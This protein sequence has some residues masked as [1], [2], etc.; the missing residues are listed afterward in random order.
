MKRFYWSLII[1]FVLNISCKTTRQET[2]QVFFV[3]TKGDD[4]A[5]G[6]KEVPFA[7]LKKALQQVVKL[8]NPTQPIDIFIR[9]GTYNIQN[10]I[11]IN[12]HVNNV[13][14]HAYKNEKVIFSG[15]ISLPVATIK[16][17][18]QN[19]YQINLKKAGITNYGNIRN[20]GF[21]RP[22]SPSWGELFV[23]GKAF[24]LARWPNKRFIPIGKV[25]DAGSIPR[26]GDFFKRGA[27]FKYDSLRISQWKKSKDIWI[28]GYFCYGYADDAVKVSKIDTLHKTITT[29]QP[30]LYGFA[31]GA[32]F[33]RW[34]AFNIFEELDEDK[35]FFIDREKGILYFVSDEKE[36]KTLHFSMLETPFFNIENAKNI[37]I[38]GIDFKYSRGIGIA[39]SNTKNVIIKNCTFSNLGS[40]GVTIGK[41]II[42]FKDYR[43]D[44]IGIPKS[45]IIGSLQQHLYANTTL[46]REGG[47][48]NSI[49]D[50]KFY[51]LGGGG[52]SLGGGNRKTLTSG[53]N[54]VENCVFHDVNRIEKS[55]RPAVHLTGV[56]NKII[57]CEIYNTPSMAVLMHGN[58]HLI[59]YN[60]IHD[61]V[62]NADDQGAF[63]YGRDPSERGTI[64][65][66]NYFENIPDKYST[67]AIYNDDGACGL[68]VEGNVFY[69]S[70]MRN[71]LLGGGSDNTYTNNIFMNAKIGI[72][73][74]N[75][76][77]NWSARIL[78]T[79]GLIEKRLKD[80]NYHQS[81]YSTQ[82]PA[83]VSYLDN[84]ALPKGN[85]VENNVFYD[86]EK[87]I[88]GNKDWL[89]F[90]NNLITKKDL[91]FVDA[92]NRNFELKKTSIV[93]KELPNFKKIPFNKI[94]LYK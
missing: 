32:D 5:K 37:I 68:I 28:S 85:L 74:D 43:H 63:Y 70:G 87:I 52:V 93:Y 78:A 91:D 60:Y 47:E 9:E 81:P 53:N 57:H 44:G 79:G 62:L 8:K 31:N 33:Q 15:G 16:K 3:S 17:N 14:I 30:T 40:L 67:C 27:V 61:V 66:Y 35:E 11:Q 65:R 42:P 20:V 77:Q 41:G 59:V 64:I 10:T 4:S 21:A 19:S 71:V 75:R 45:G 50:C 6:T 2:K 39:M 48:D 86:V 58:N 56:G 26:N 36:L 54:R 84:A 88:D 25:L 34:Y 94:G 51:Q 7:T 69:K 24:H 46:N 29:A 83:L 72:H 92:K 22:L 90:K 49:I 82:Y 55:Y 73:V 76:L 18:D 89:I 13:R 1:L 23:N 38:E 12:H 80:V